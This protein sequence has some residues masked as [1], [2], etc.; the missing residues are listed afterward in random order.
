MTTEP[1]E[2]AEE[3]TDDGDTVELDNGDTLRLRIQPDDNINPFDETDIYGRVGWES[4][5]RNDYGYHERPSDFD[6][7]AEKL[8]VNGDSLWWQP[9]ADVKRSDEHFARLRDTVR[10]LAEYGY[11]GVI[12]EKLSGQDAYHRPIVV[13]VASLWGIE[14][15]PTPEY[16]KEIVGDLITEVMG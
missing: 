3:L 13:N 12:V 14:P 1:K 16:L 9:P 6:G 8:T 7:N 4:R 2:L 15:H 10:E 11:I 5:R